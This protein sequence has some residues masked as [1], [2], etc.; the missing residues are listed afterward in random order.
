MSCKVATAALAL[1]LL[2]ACAPAPPPAPEAPRALPAGSSYLD[3]ALAPSDRGDVPGVLGPLRRAAATPPRK[4]AL[5]RGDI[6][7]LLAQ[8]EA[9]AKPETADQ[10]I[11]EM[12]T[13]AFEAFVERGTLTRIPYFHD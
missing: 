7:L 12:K 5:P 4:A 8:A 6:D 13:E 9:A 2:A 3:D 1:L 11:A 10:R